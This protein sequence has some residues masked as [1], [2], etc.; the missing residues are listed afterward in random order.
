MVDPNSVR[1]RLSLKA[2]KPPVK[3]LSE[4]HNSSQMR[5]LARVA[6]PRQFETSLVFAS[7]RR[8][9]TD[10]RPAIEKAPSTSSRQRL[11][12][13]LCWG[14]TSASGT[15]VKFA[16]RFRMFGGGSWRRV[17]QSLHPGTLELP[18]GTLPDRRLAPAAV[19][20]TG[21]SK[22]LQNGRK[23]VF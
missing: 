17:R 13:E 16:A 18:P 5:E 21:L 20:N 22:R 6:E 8:R 9:F 4:R 11:C 14:S 7:P 3:R 19:C 1:R 23:V 12:G 15:A 10:Q 2:P